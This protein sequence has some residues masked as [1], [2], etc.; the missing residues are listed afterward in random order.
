[1]VIAET[2]RGPVP[3]LVIENCLLLTAGLENVE[4]VL[5]EG[6]SEA[7]NLTLRS[8]RVEV[9]GLRVDSYW[10]FTALSYAKD[11]EGEMRMYKIELQREREV[12]KAVAIVV[13]KHDSAVLLVVPARCAPEKTQPKT[14]M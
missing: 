11:L 6:T 4:A 1:V 13:K 2:Q 10:F 9:G 7:E 5:S 14:H 12:Q 3:F 8:G